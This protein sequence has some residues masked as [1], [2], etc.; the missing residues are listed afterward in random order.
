MRCILIVFF[1]C[2]HIYCNAATKPSGR[3]RLK[4]GRYFTSGTVSKYHLRLN[5][6]M[7]AE[8]VD[9]HRII[10]IICKGN[11]A[12]FGCVPTDANFHLKNGQ[13]VKLLHYRTSQRYSI[14]GHMKYK[15]EYRLS[16][17]QIK[18]MSKSCVLL[19]SIHLPE[20]SNIIIFEKPLKYSR[21]VRLEKF[22]AKYQ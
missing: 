15:S 3:I 7:R 10:T 1:V 6:F 19:S 17:D 9:T 12:S 8:I 5:V 20:C 4:L 21:A 22:F 18:I 13:T 11:Y 2:L 14:L 16:V